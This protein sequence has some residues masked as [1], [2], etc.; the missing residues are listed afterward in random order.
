MKKIEKKGF[1]M[2]SNYIEDFVNPK[3][4]VNLDFDNL[5]S[6]AEVKEAE[7][8]SSILRLPVAI[9]MFIVMFVCLIN[10]W[11]IAL[12][13][14]TMLAFFSFP[15]TSR[16][17]QNSMKVEFPNKFFWSIVLIM[18]MLVTASIYVHKYA[19]DVKKAEATALVEQQRQAELAEKAEQERIEK[20]KEQQRLDSLSFHMNLAQVKI[21]ERKL[22][23]AVQEYELAWPFMDS[24]TK[25]VISYKMANI[26]FANKL[27]E[28]AL[29]YYWYARI[30]S[31]QLDTL[32]YNKALCHVKVGDLPAAV[33]ALRM[34]PVRSPR[35]VTLFNKIN[36]IKSRITYVDKPVQ[37]KRVAYYTILCGDGSFSHSS[38]RRGTCSRHGGVADWQHPVYENY[39]EN[40]KKKLVEK[41][42]EYGEL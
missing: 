5:I 38:S 28:K 41:Y 39:T 17:L 8:S 24:E 26:L 35:V 20:E 30:D 15:K 33:S 14:S 23:D 16:W 10:L 31:A 3:Y 18:M 1:A 13:F 21:D 42:R 11:W 19:D 6:C 25:G 7:H 4:Y 34:S 12:A 2:K 36:P 22:M 37:K 29:N 27:Y 32:H 9:L 40:Q